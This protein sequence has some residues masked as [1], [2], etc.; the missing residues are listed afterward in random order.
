MIHLEDEP[1]LRLVLPYF[2][3]EL[4]NEKG[5]FLL[6]AHKV[7]SLSDIIL[8]RPALDYILMYCVID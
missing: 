1:P 8:T 5:A 2:S 7:T 4:K 3:K 6:N